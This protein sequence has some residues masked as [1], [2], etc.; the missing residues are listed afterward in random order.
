MYIEKITPR[1]K[2]VLQLISE[3]HSCKEIA[4]K[5]YISQNTVNTHR[6]NLLSKFQTRNSAGLVRMGF[7]HGILKHKCLWPLT[8]ELY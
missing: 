7:E 4:S 3:A 6:K 8:S 5:L 1:E 2:E